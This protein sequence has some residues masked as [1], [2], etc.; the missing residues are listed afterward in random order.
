MKLLRILILPAALLLFSSVI[1]S[2]VIKDQ[3]TAHSDG[4][5]IIVE[6][7]TLDE[8]GVVRFDVMRSTDVNGTFFAVGSREPTGN[9]S[10]Y[11]YTDN[12]V[13]KATGG[14]YVYKIRTYFG[15]R[16]PVDSETASVQHLS[17]A[18]RRTWGSIKA[19]FR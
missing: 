10:S 2:A 12:Q 8:S 18:Y 9:N 19:M 6:W 16:P 17:S 3:P 13:F 4:S 1:I 5:A 11:K 14:F 7:N 15:D